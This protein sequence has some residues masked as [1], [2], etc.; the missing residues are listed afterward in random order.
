MNNY[1]L[2][3]DD[4][5]PIRV[6]G[7]WTSEKL[8]YLRRYIS[9]F[10]TSMRGNPWRQRNYIDMYAGSGKF[11]ESDN[12]EVQLGSALVALTTDHP[13]TNY[14]FS[15]SNPDNIS[16]LKTRTKQLPF[17]VEYRVGNANQIVHQIVDQ[18][19]VID[20]QKLPGQWSSL[21]L[22]FLDPDGLELEWK[23]I[24]CLAS[25]Y[26]MD[27]IIYYSQY[28]L[29]INF[30]NCYQAKEETDIDRF[31]GTDQWRKIYE[32]RTKKGS[33]SG[34]HRDLIDL[35]KNNLSLLG[36]KSI[37]D[38][39]GGCEPI[40]RNTKQAPL[41]RLIFASKHK[42][43]HDFWNKVTERDMYGNKRLF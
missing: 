43:G 39:E 27:L 4:G 15:D 17:N 11:R 28:G 33:I 10:E 34:I 3:E 31:F 36:Y 24:Q 29:N 26:T 38:Q 13:F 22:A 25:L 7:P 20:D 23:T 16:T 35:Y 12:G 32:Q 5:F 30:K 18:I 1:L 8:D 14:F 21:N 9:M 41:Y 42:R 2:P 37:V 19:R 6:F 40:M